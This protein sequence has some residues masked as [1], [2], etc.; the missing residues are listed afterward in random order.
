MPENIEQNNISKIDSELSGIDT[1]IQQKM[2]E[3]ITML[4][5]GGATRE[6]V[7]SLDQFSEA[8]IAK[9]YGT[10]APA[11]PSGSLR[12]PTENTEPSPEDKAL[13]FE[14]VAGIKANQEKI[15][16][17]KAERI[18][19]KEEEELS[20]KKNTPKPKEVEKNRELDLAEIDKKISQLN[21]NNPL[22]EVEKKNLEIERDSIN[23]YYNNYSGG[24][25]NNDGLV[26][27]VSREKLEE[28]K[29]DIE[30][31]EKVGDYNEVLRLVRYQIENQKEPTTV[32]IQQFLNKYKNLKDKIYG[33]ELGRAH[34][35]LEIKASEAVDKG[36]GRVVFYADVFDPEGV[37]PIKLKC[38]SKEEMY[39]IVEDMNN[40]ALEKIIL[41]IKKDGEEL[42]VEKKKFED[43]TL[44]EKGIDIE[45]RRGQ[46]LNTIKEDATVWSGEY[47]KEDGQVRLTFTRGSKTEIEGV[48][49]EKYDAELATLIKLEVDVN[50][51]PKPSAQ[52]S[53]SENKP[54]EKSAEI[55]KDIEELGEAKL[56]IEI[57]KVIKKF[58]ETLKKKNI[59]Y[60]GLDIEKKSD[61]FHL[62]AHLTGTGLKGLVIQ[63]PDF[64][65][66][67][68]SRDG[69]IIVPTHKLDAND[70]VKAFV[71]QEDIDKFA[72]T[73][74]EEIKKYI[75]EDRKKK[76]ERI[77]I[78]N[79]VLKITYK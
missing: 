35:I 57:E 40:R 17:L 46:A 79:G 21:I 68:K 66:D 34:S 7:V 62:V 38:A 1:S 52:T 50:A 44:E 32:S 27:V 47:I 3:A 73:I 19:L 43:M 4:K 36:K 54:S 77:D 10:E 75:E 29:L 49:N 60:K 18:L 69:K 64:I 41:K 15:N 65:A 53:G 74:G 20:K 25:D 37:D 2:F 56:K 67:I 78:E 30:P 28:K 14:M 26:N 16:K 23:D 55:K 8:D 9:V 24:G 59:A 33:I 71:K 31:E 39:K 11:I 61:G 6:K 76:V 58:A 22:Y 45:K 63:N 70:I 72:D 42:K 12:A 13:F 5:E 51:I 48:L